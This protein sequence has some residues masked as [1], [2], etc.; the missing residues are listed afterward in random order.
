MQPALR[1]PIHRIAASRT[2]AGMPMSQ[3]HMVRQSNGP[4]Q[5]DRFTPSLAVT[6]AMQPART[7]LDV[8]QPTLPVCNHR[9]QAASS[10][11]KSL[12]PS[13]GSRFDRR[14]RCL[15]GMTDLTQNLC[16]EISVSASIIAVILLQPADPSL[17]EGRKLV[18]EVFDSKLGWGLQQGR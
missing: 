10:N 3:L 13:C 7:L 12:L 1:L 15:T 6:Q 9:I 4:T 2:P 8:Q 18:A 11:P 16:R 14:R 5:V 17:L